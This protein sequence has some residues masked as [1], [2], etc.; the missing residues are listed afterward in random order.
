MTQKAARRIATLAADRGRIGL[1][2]DHVQ[3]H[4]EHNAFSWCISAQSELQAA[5]GDKA[6]STRVRVIESVAVAAECGSCA[7]YNAQAPRVMPCPLLQVS[8][9]R[10]S[11]SSGGAL[12]G[13]NTGGVLSGGNGG[14]AAD[15]S[16]RGAGQGGITQGGNDNGDRSNNGNGQGG[17][18]GG[19]NGEGRGANGGGGNQ[20]GNNGEWRGDNAE[21]RNYDNRGG[22]R[23]DNQYVTTTVGSLLL[24]DA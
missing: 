18:R 1:L 22:Y 2:T 4:A 15:A 23:Y 13:G 17:N 10:T 20:G 12:T 7:R 21:N 11:G 19:D 9:I 8:T 3:E 5:V 16:K 14:G 6:A 24:H